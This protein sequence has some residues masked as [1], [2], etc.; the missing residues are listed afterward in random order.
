MTS[1]ARG[2]SSTAAVDIPRVAG[3]LLTGGASRR[4]GTDKASLIVGDDTLAIRLG[5]ILNAVCRP[6]WEVGPGRSGLE[7]VTEPE[8]GLGPLSAIVAGEHALERMGWRGPVL[9]LSCDLPLLTLPAAAKLALWPGEESV[10]PYVGGRAQPLCA[11]WSRHH[12]LEARLRWSSGARSL[13]DLPT[14]APCVAFKAPESSLA[15]YAD[16]DTPEEL[17]ALLGA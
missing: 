13:G 16:A 10:V 14:S 11:R 15:A 5:R 12:L 8:P 9:V 4:M 6:V 17:A 7:E 3:L 1:G 2:V